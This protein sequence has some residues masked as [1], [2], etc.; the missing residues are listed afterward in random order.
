M[1]KSVFGESGIKPMPVRKARSDVKFDSGSASSSGGSWK[2]QDGI[3][4]KRDVPN[5]AGKMGGANPQNSK[6][7]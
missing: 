4:P 2:G 7:R 3:T 5:K 1:G 6:I